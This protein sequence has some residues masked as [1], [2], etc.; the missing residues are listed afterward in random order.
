MIQVPTQLDISDLLNA[1]ADEQDNGNGWKDINELR[2]T[3]RDYSGLQYSFDY[4]I[5]NKSEKDIYCGSGAA[6]GK[7]LK[8]AVAEQIEL[9]RNNDGRVKYRVIGRDVEKTSVKDFSTQYGVFQST[10]NGEFGGSIKLPNGEEISGNFKYVFDVGDK[11]YAIGR[12]AHMMSASTNI[13]QF[14][15]NLEYITVYNTVDAMTALIYAV[16]NEYKPVENIYCDVVDIG[17]NEAYA[18]LTGYIE[19]TDELG[20]RSYWDEERILRITEDGVKEINR[21]TGKKPILITSLIVNEN[22]IYISC[23][24][25]VIH[26]NRINNKITYYTCLTKGDEE[27]LRRNINS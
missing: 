17:D 23:D 11:V 13:Y 21:F 12:L 10:D 5:S 4:I 8:A 27:E 26:I 1:L 7:W 22:D 3:D 9:K 6:D 19:K 18:L 24:K 25:M 20:N 16:V 2:I 15:K 14:N